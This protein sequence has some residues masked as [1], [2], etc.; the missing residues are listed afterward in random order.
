MKYLQKSLILFLFSFVALHAQAQEA[1][2]TYS[3]DIGFNAIVFQNFFGSGSAPFTILYKKYSSENKATRLGLS[4]SL[5]FQ[6]AKATPSNVSYTTNN[7]ASV[8]LIIG[9]ESQQVISER[10]VWFFGGDLIPNFSYSKF[11]QFDPTNSDTP[12]NTVISYGLDIRP[13]LGLR[14]NINPRLYIATEFSGILGYR[15]TD[16]KIKFPTQT[17]ELNTDDLN[18]SLVPASALFLFYRF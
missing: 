9:K 14:F 5:N 2:K 17:N 11:D 7:N 13:F 16:R 18:L 12:L 15:H 6:S 3:H 10:W 8:S 1:P 4:T